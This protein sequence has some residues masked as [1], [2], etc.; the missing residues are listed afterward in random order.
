MTILHIPVLRLLQILCH[1]FMISSFHYH[2]ARSYGIH[3]VSYLLVF[4]LLLKL[5]NCYITYHN[6]L[7]LVDS[8]LHSCIT[9]VISCVFNMQFLCFER[10]WIFCFMFVFFSVICSYQCERYCI[11]VVDCDLQLSFLTLFLAGLLSIRG[12]L[13]DLTVTSI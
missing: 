6:Q 5:H 2:I 11:H 10:F 1:M 13:S 12:L 8:H 7:P 3:V 4:G 9:T